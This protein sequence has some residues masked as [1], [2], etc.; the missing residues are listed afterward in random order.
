MA[1]EKEK[2]INRLIE[3][4]KENADVE[5]QPEGKLRDFTPNSIVYI[6]FIVMIETEFEI[7][8]GDSVLVNS[9]D[10]TF[11]ELVDRIIEE[12]NKQ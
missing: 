9:D 4:I 7:E 8:F 2:V 3:L 10:L 6:K 11:D 12:K 5:I 1:Q